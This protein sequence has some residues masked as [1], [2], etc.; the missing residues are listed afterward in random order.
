MEVIS[1]EMQSAHSTTRVQKV[2]R[3]SEELVHYNIA[4][5]CTSFIGTSLTI[6]Y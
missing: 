5:A 4:G 6:F 2:S 1:A 3:E